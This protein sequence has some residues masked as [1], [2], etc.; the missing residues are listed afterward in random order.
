MLAR[1]ETMILLEKEIPL[2]AIRKQIASAVDIIVQLGRLRD[3]TRRVLEIAEV[4]GCVEG[5]IELNRLFFFE[6]EIVPD[7]EKVVG[8][9]KK[10]SELICFQKLKKAGIVRREDYGS[11]INISMENVSGL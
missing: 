5:E 4:L 8:A 6:E 2:L 9:L 7:E 10:V 11:M 1:L 3:G